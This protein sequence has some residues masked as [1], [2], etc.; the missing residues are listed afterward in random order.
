LFLW[1]YYGQLQELEKRKTAWACRTAHISGI[2]FLR[3]KTIKIFMHRRI[4][5]AQLVQN[6]FGSAQSKCL[7]L[8]PSSLHNLL[9]ASLFRHT[10]MPA[11]VWAMGSKCAFKRN[12][13][14]YSV[15]SVGLSAV[16]FAL[17]VWVCICVCLCVCECLCVS[18]CVCKSVCFK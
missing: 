7:V 8:Q 6:S 13:E 14:Y 10:L 17:Q 4:A 16:A 15:G 5:G 18:V 11:V 12:A 3:I 9:K 2:S 1:P